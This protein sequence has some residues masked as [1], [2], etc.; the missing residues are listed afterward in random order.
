MSLPDFLI[1][2]AMKAGTTSLYHDLQQNP[3]IYMSSDKEPGNLGSDEVLTQ[4]GKCAYEKFFSKAT[5]NQICGE[6]ST[7]YSKLPDFPGVPKRAKQLLGENLKVIYIVRDPIARIIS[8]HNHELISGRV[9]C[10]IDEAIQNYPRFI[11]YSKYAM[12][13]APWTDALGKEQVL[14]IGFESYS[15]G[16]IETLQRVCRFLEIDAH[17]DMIN[18]EVIHNRTKGKPRTAGLLNKLSRIGLYRQLVRQFLSTTV[19]DI[20]R[21]RLLP[22]ASITT[23]QLSTETLNYL[24][25]EIGPDADRLKQI[26]GT[27]CPDWAS[28]DLGRCDLKPN[29]QGLKDRSSVTSGDQKYFAE[30]T[31]EIEQ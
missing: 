3:A 22:R 13:I 20:L 9:T 21:K 25:K 17:S 29:A 11:N 12:Q 14:V 10:G 4:S 30:K 27:D 24:V 6:A 7:A 1:I 18:T 23:N 16:R 19:R 31:T 15:A 8:Q 26:M 5:P 28:V 2:G